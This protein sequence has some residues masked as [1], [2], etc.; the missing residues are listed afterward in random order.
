MAAG[1]AHGNLRLFHY[2]CTTPRAEFIGNIVKIVFLTHFFY[3]YIFTFFIEEK[4]ASSAVVA[5]RFLF[6]DIYLITVGGSDATLLR[7][8]II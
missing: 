1:D 8:K 4:T 7:W 6:E 3:K 2:P 5:I